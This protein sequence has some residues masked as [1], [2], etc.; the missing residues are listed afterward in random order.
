MYTQ[1]SEPYPSTRGD[2]FGAT[3]NR[4]NPH[5]GQDTAPGGLPAL[6]L[7]DGT[8][9]GTRKSKE[10][11][12]VVVIAHSDGKFSGYAH[13]AHTAGVEVGKTI[14]RGEGFGLIGSTGTA[15]TGRHLHYTLGNDTWGVI[16]GHVE[17][18][19]EY[20]NG[21]INPAS[22]NG[23]MG[24]EGDLYTA[25]VDDGDPGPIYYELAQRFSNKHFGTHLDTDGIKGPFTDA[26]IVRIVAEAV[27]ADDL[28]KLAKTDANE[29]GER[30]IN[31]WKRVQASSNKHFGTSL[32]IDGDPAHWSFWAETKIAAAILNAEPGI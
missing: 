2:K 16:E 29:N 30:G 11:G 24:I 32:T 12:N 23:H 25:A 22:F 7:A 10:L 20:I 15:T 31:Y 21:H 18:P 4:K 1:Y 13:L 8:F 19:I 26:C 9:I 5:R 6:A 27:N 14:R 28:G 3:E 17:D